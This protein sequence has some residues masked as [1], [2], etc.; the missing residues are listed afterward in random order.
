MKPIILTVMILL[1][2]S[3]SGCTNKSADQVISAPTAPADVPPATEAAVAPEN[4]AVENNVEKAEDKPKMEQNIWKYGGEA[5]SGK[6]ADADVVDLGNG[7]FRMYYS[8]E[9]E[10][11]GFKGQVYSALSSDGMNWKTEAGTRLEWAIFPSVIKLENG[12]YRMYYQNSGAIKS[13]A[14]SDGLNWKE[15]AGVRIDTVNNAA[16]TL[17]NVGAPT[18]IK[19]G[20][21]YL[22]AY[23]G[24]VDEKYPEKVPN[25]DTHLFLWAESKDGLAFEKKGIA[26]DSRNDEF[27]GW[28]DGPEFTSWDDS[29]LRLYFWSYRGVYHVTFSAGK[30][31]SDPVFDYTTENDPNIMF[32]ENPP[33]DPTLAKIGGKWFLYYGQHEKGIYYATF[34]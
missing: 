15:D 6:Y 7:Q 8:A 11:P 31:S 5:I 16:L 32:P 14:S 3:V 2:I 18:V 21:K 29:S 26:L 25:P 20:D 28:L 24:V 22:I 30:F 23:S 1:M 13:A 10:V 9:P 27:K 4:P 17:S 33:G 34:K 12:K 19:N